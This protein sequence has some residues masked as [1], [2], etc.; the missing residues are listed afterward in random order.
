MASDQSAAAASNRSAALPSEELQR[1]GRGEITLDE[2]L[3][4][5]VEQGVAHLRAL[6]P[7][8]DLDIIRETLRAQL[9]TDPRLAALVRQATGQDPQS[10]GH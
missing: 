3:R 2:Y 1:L 10:S 5:R 6:L 7:E 8:A 9:V 4:L